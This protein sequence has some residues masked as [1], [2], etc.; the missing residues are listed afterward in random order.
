MNRKI[1]GSILALIMASMACSTISLDLNRVVGSGRVISEARNVS[2]FTSIELA[3]SAEVNVQLGPKESVTVE[4]D[5]NVVP[6]IETTVANGK[7]LIST[8]PGINLTTSNGVHV[9]VV[10]KS[11]N[12]ITLSG[13]G[14]IFVTGMS[15]PELTIELPGSGNINV[16]GTVDHVGIN[17]LGSGNIYCV[18]LRAV[19]ADVKLD[20]SGNIT[21]HATQS[22][23]AS[24]SGSG[25]IQYR[26]RP[27]QI[28]KNITGSGSITP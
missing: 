15:G 26:G 25:S 22:L 11:L 8:K 7:L 18:T 17:L 13:S 28:T 24:L 12:G 6:L 23:N 16:A 3:G 21:L 1:L 9:N 20:G 10:M 27:A 5:D 2:D 14:K 4:A 19:S